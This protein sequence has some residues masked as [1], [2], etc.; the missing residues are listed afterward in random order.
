VHIDTCE[1]TPVQERGGFEAKI[2]PFAGAREQLDFLDFLP[3]IAPEPRLPPSVRI[4]GK[5]LYSSSP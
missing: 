5:T 3:G 4:S 2:A 1:P